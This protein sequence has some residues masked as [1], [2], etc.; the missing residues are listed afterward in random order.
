MI[1]FDNAAT[2]GKKPFGVIIKTTLSM[3][4]CANPGRS[5]HTRSLKAAN[6]VF[7]VRAKLKSFFNVPSEE[8]VIFTQNCTHALN[9]GIA[10]CQKRGGHI[11]CSCFEHNSV[12]RCLNKLM[13][14]GKITYSVAT[15]QDKEI[16]TPGDIESLIKPDTYMVCLIHT[17]NTTGVTHDIE[18]VGKL[19]KERGLIFLVDA[20][21][22]A[23]H[24]K[25]DMQKANINLLAF[26]GHKGL[27]APQS[28]GGLC[29]NNINPNPIIFGGTGTNSIDLNQPNE[30]PEKY[31]SGTVSTPLILGLGKGIHYVSK[32]FDKHRIKVEALTKYL[33][34]KLVQVK[35]MVLYSPA[36]VNSGVVLFNIKNY[37]SSEVGD[38][39][40]DC[41]IAVRSGLHCAPL[42]HKFLGTVKTGAVRVSLNHFNKKREIDKLIAALN[43]LK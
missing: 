27:L 33:L 34:Q 6:Q 42:T 36:S 32:N 41:G 4:R 10:G 35:G 1:Y 19:C 3:L 11:I 14:D 30:P 29:I 15:P 23:G 22:S 9:L 39:L 20:A 18:A 8:N 26:A 17:T 7:E 21:Q 2:S 5:G 37:T 24:I 25:I 28:I 38:F 43:K 13:C 12:L 16:V 40:N 31:E